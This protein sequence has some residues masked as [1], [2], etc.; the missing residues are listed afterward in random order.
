[1]DLGKHM[2]TYGGLRIVEWLRGFATLMEL[3]GSAYAAEG[4]DSLVRVFSRSRLLSTLQRAGLTETC[5][6]QFITHATMTKSRV[7][8]FDRPLIEIGETKLLLFVPAV[9]ASVLGQIVLSAMAGVKESQINEKGPGFEKRVLQLLV[10]HGRSPVTIRTVRDNA[11]FDYD[12]MF[13]WGDYCFL[14]E[15]KNHSLSRNVPKLAYH[16]KRE[17]DANVKQVRR[18]MDGLVKHPD[19]LDKQLPEARGK[20][21]VPCV[22]N[23]LPYSLLGGIDGVFFSDYSSIARFFE[24]PTVGARIAGSPIKE[25][26]AFA[27]MWSGLTP[28]PEDL[29]R[30]IFWSYQYGVA[31]RHMELRKFSQTLN[32][33]IQITL[34]SW[35]RQPTG[36]ASGK[37]A[38]IEHRQSFEDHGGIDY[39]RS[40]LTRLP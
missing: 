3:S 34:G 24:M 27:S 17:R 29:L 21:L 9:I 2:T 18:L 31:A 7:D 1:M 32:D 30:H 35:D 15:C 4:V 8:L 19:M 40:I 25:E 5:A 28:T 16:F 37:A 12:V 6:R 22:V 23:S 20:L 33:D 10:V 38:S 13:V 14:F 11:E 26:N 36:I 39:V